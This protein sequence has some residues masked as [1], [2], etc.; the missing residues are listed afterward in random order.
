LLIGEGRKLK[1]SYVILLGLAIFI[2]VLPGIVVPPAKAETTP[3][4]WTDKREYDPHSIAKIFG[5]G[6][7]PFSTITVTIVRPDLVED[8]V[9][10]STDEF[11]YFACEYLLDGI[12]G[13]F[14]VTATDGENTATTTFG[15]CLFLWA[16]L[17]HCT[18]GTFIEARAYGLCWCKSYHVKYFDPDGVLRRTSPTY[19]HRWFFKDHYVILPTL[20]KILG[21]WTVKLY[22]GTTLK[23][24]KTVDVNKIVWTTDSAYYNMCLTYSQGETL[25][26]KALGL[27]ST[28]YYRVQLQMPNGSRFYISDW[29]TGV[30]TLTGSY[31]LPLNAPVGKWKLH[32][33]QANDAC[34]SGERHY[35]DCC[36]MVTEAQYYYLTVRTD[37]EG[38][39]TIPGEGWYLEGDYVNLT[40]PDYVPVN[41][42]FRYR[43]SYWDVDGVSQGTGV[44]DITICMDANHTA[45][46]HYVSQYYLNLTTNPPGVTVPSGV[47]WYDAG[48]T[49]SIFTPEFIGISPGVSRYR[50]DGWTT[51]D[52]SEI[53][54]ASATSTTVYLDKPKTVTANYR[55]QYHVTFDQ[56]GLDA[57]ATGTVVTV[58]GSDKTFADLPYSFWADEGSV[59]T[60]SYSSQ[61]SSTTSGKR[62]VLESVSG[63]ASPV[64]V[65][66]AVNI[67][68]NYKTQYKLTVRTSGL[69]T[70]VTNVYNET[71][72]LGTATDASPYTEW[73]DEG[74]LILLD[75]DSPIVDGNQRFVFNYWSG[76][77]SGSNRP[78]SVTMDSAKDVTANYGT[79]YLVTFDQTGLDATANGVIVTVNGSDKTFAELPFS[80]WVDEGATVTYSYNNSIPGITSGK[81]FVLTSVTGPASPFTVTSSVTVTGN[82]KVQYQVT[83]DQTG[84]GVDYAG[85]VVT[86]DGVDYGVGDL[87][88]SFWWDGNSDHNFAFSSPLTVNSGKRYLW[89]STTGLSTSQAGTITVTASGTVTG[90]YKTQF[91]VTFDQTGVGVDFSGVVVT[92]DGTDYNVAGLPVSFWWDEGSTHDFAFQSPLTVTANAKRYVWTSTTGL[93]TLQSDTITVSTDGTVTGNYKTQY[94]LEVTSTYGSPT[95]TSGWFDDGTSITASVNSPVSG[96]PGTRYVCTGWTGTGSVPASGSTTSV[97]FTISEPSSITW[98]W[99]T[100]Y[101]LT[102]QTDPS[103]LSPAPTPSSGWFDEGEDVTLTAPDESYLGSDRYLFDYWDVDGASQGA[104]INPITVHMD[105]PH[106]A[107]AHYVY[108]PA[109]SVSVSPEDTTII[110]GDSVHFTS[111]VTGGVSPY[112]YQ[113]YLNDA[114]VSGAN[115]SSWTF[116]PTATGTYYVYLNVTDS[117]GTWAKSN[118]AKVTVLPPAPPV[119]GVTVPT[120]KSNIPALT[121]AYSLTIFALASAFVW[122]RRKTK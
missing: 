84:V 22:Q 11:G 88:A 72:I 73:F 41:A 31:D 62:F 118:V 120:E 58:N 60:Y 86:I 38:I 40:A 4:V 67:C 110:I 95:P 43:F 57:T 105:A 66:S 93:S 111:T 53:A 122:I 45:T 61:V 87:P 49:V 98:N 116:T 119:G 24:T 94:Y 101:Y 39:T 36:F 28:K 89:T 90:N 85:T 12:H 81:R 79:Q 5:Y 108:A 29:T 30:T 117:T 114:P 92:V 83:F 51:A 6:F 121:F 107:T 102:V 21:T 23:R 2:L 82:Y 96:P 13:T 63:P 77:A 47:G 50:F 8:I 59:L 113:W 37:P 115:E 20:P 68:G 56:S 100:Q 10:T 65:N 16:R 52:M 78:V 1:K 7:N 48:E 18:I 97:T 70:H 55:V 54:N 91:K 103:G 71:D 33:R 46:A 34:G 26:Y 15:N 9:T 104:G 19:T 99:K 32:V 112:S 69:G 74:T 80:M 3:I 42:S 25:Y 75:I 17:K 106:T 35:V 27:V 109:L 76:D 44:T 14:N 64:T